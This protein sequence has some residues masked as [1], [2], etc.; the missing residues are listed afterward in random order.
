MSTE[1]IQNVSDKYFYLFIYLI[2]LLICYDG[3]II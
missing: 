2:S 3:Y 1:S